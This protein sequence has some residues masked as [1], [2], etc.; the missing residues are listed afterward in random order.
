ML[1]G[2]DPIVIFLFS[3]K[4]AEESLGDIPIVKSFVA[5]LPLLPIP[6]YLS[7]RLTGLYVDSEEKSIDIETTP[8]TLINGK[9]PTTTQK[10][11][12]ST[13]RVNMLA[14]RNSIGMTLFSALA[15]RI[16]EKVTSKEYSITYL[17]GAVTVFGGLLNSFN[18]TQNSTNDLYNVSFEITRGQIETTVEEPTAALQRNTGALPLS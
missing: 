15:D 1:N 8:E 13:I 6:L 9:P 18:I 11:L 10:G 3:K 12:N 7:E 4:V 14:S 5:K 17:N 2:I 16:F